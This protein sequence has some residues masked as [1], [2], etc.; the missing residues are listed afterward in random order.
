MPRS[1][2]VSVPSVATRGTWRE[3][4]EGEVPSSPRG[5]FRST[6]QNWIIS[7]NTMQVISRWGLYSLV[8]DGTVVY[9]YRW[10]V[11]L[12]KVYWVMWQRNRTGTRDWLH[13]GPQSDPIKACCCCSGGGPGVW[14]RRK[15]SRYSELRTSQNCIASAWSI[16]AAQYS[17]SV[18]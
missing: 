5:I 18:R 14:W 10:A 8:S 11:L 12:W 1:P 9:S 15:P 17:R 3:Q 2:P 4:W 7:Q 13:Y 6:Q 16:Y